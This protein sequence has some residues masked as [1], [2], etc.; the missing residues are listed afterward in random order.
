[1]GMVRNDINMDVTKISVYMEFKTNLYKIHIKLLWVLDSKQ[2][3][4]CYDSREKNSYWEVHIFKTM[5]KMKGLFGKFSGDFSLD[6]IKANSQTVK[7]PLKV[8]LVTMC[9]IIRHLFKQSSEVFHK[10]FVPV[11]SWLAF[12]ISSFIGKLS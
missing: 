5:N 4:D 6:V 12:L 2:L 1:M 11:C 9:F 7:K 8:S 10:R 3:K